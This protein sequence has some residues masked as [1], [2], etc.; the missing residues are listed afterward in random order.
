M[1]V[2][3]TIYDIA[4]YQILD[5]QSFY[6]KII[7]PYFIIPSAK[8]QIFE[9]NTINEHIRLTL[10]DSRNYL[11]FTNTRI[12]FHY[13]GPNTDLEKSSSNIKDCYSLLSALKEK[14][15][16]YENAFETIQCYA[17][18]EYDM[19]YDELADLMKTQNNFDTLDS[20]TDVGIFKQ[21][22]YKGYEV[23]LQY[24][25]YVHEK[26]SKRE[27]LFTLDTE[28]R[29]KYSDKT[30]ILVRCRLKDKPSTNSHSTYKAKSKVITELIKSLLNS[31]E[32]E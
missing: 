5:F 26:D 29:H 14:S 27:G 31:Y 11:M 30:A 12:S 3:R 8:Y 17:L 10:S 18:K 16:F 2:V 22:G 4:Y 7:N 15:N 13:D 19:A 20:Y 24:G 25:L 21:G 9:E 6:R 1:E 28:M 23:D 32:Q